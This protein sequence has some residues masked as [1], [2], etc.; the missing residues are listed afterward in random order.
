M[1]EPSALIISLHADTR[2]EVNAKAAT[3]E[4][5]LLQVVPQVD[6]E[7]QHIVHAG[8]YARTALI[9]KGATL[10][11]AQMNLDNI[12]VLYGDISVTTAEGV[13]RLTG[14][15]VLPAVAGYKRVGYA[16][17]DT[18]WT[19]F[20]ATD[21]TD[22]EKIENLATDESEKLQTRTLAIENRESTVIRLE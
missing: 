22:I 18:W 13:K 10:T 4:K 9:R 19:T 5:P 15:H 1:N 3:L 16:H 11:G 17:E 7:T 6:L 8:M 12:C 2:E 14:Y 20:I 21:E